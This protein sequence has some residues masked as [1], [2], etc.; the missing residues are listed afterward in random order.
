MTETDDNR[1]LLAY[2]RDGDVKSLSALVTRH[3]K[4]LGAYLRGLLSSDAD[5]EDAFQETWMRVIRSCGSYRGGSV[6]AYLTKIAR[7]VAIDRFR[8]GRRPTLSLDLPD[9][10]GNDMKEALADPIPAPDELF[11]TSAT[12]ADIREAVKALPEGPREVLLMR[13]ESELAFKEIA[14]IMSIPLGTALTWMRTATLKLKQK[15]GEKK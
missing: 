9:D 15:L 7:S 11:E 10:D 5:A 3:T 6:R 8:R 14:E 1:L 12:A 2:A 13:I 4:W